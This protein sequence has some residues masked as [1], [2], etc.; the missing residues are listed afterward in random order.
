MLNRKQKLEKLSNQMLKLQKTMR[1]IA[2]ELK[3]QS[4]PE[5]EMFSKGI[6][7]LDASDILGDWAKVVIADN[8]VDEHI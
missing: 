4:N 3:K 1:N 2:N 7:L 6:Q 8:F 5:F